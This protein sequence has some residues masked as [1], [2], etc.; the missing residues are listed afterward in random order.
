VKVPVA[1]WWGAT[2]VLVPPAHGA[3][4]ARAIPAAVTR[5]TSAGHLGDPDTDV[6]LLQQWLRDG[7]VAWTEGR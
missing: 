7:V 5:A 1:L 4:L 2:D 3:W 6:V